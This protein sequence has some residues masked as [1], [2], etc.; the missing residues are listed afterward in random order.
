VSLYIKQDQVVQTSCT[1]LW[2]LDRIDQ[3]RLPMDGSYH[4]DFTGNNVN[5]YVLDTG[6][7]ESKSLLSTNMCYFLTFF[8]TLVVLVVQ[9]LMEQHKLAQQQY[10]LTRSYYCRLGRRQ[11][12]QQHQRMNSLKDEPHARLAWLRYV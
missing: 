10:H 9:Y 7:Q 11:Q 5:V 12:Q 3:Q 1:A 4:Y 6:V 2:G 8:L